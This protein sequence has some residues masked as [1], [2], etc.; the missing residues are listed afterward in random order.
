MAGIVEEHRG[1]AQKIPTPQ[2]EVEP[3][4]SLEDVG[5]IILWVLAREAI[6]HR[7]DDPSDAQLVT[8]ILLESLVIAEVPG[9]RPIAADQPDPGVFILVDQPAL[10]VEEVDVEPDNQVPD[11]PC[12]PG[13]LGPFEVE[14]VDVGGPF[15]HGRLNL[16]VGMDP[17]WTL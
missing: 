3:K 13:K 9:D 17:D 15:I 12:L 8:A 1:D 5:V 7:R 4:A 14:V 16:E 6:W 10:R 11:D 2:R